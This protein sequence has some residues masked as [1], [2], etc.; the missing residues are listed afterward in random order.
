MFT[1]GEGDPAQFGQGGGEAS[2]DPNRPLLGDV[3]KV[4]EG[5]E[6][7]YI[8]KEATVIRRSRRSRTGCLA[9]RVSASSIGS[10]R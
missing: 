2:T 10:V 4:I 1:G 8:G 6:A 3:V 7:S 9:T 5:G